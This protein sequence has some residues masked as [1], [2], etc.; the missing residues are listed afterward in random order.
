MRQLQHPSRVS[1]YVQGR[2]ASS[3]L[4]FST[5]PA[6]SCGVLGQMKLGV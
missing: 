3:C 6:F 1:S 5:H 4:R 2:D